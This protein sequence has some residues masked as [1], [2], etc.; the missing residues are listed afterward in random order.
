MDSGRIGSGPVDAGPS[1]GGVDTGPVDAGPRDCSIHVSLAGLDAAGRGSAAMPFRSFGQAIADAGSTDVICVLSGTY[2]EDVVIDH[3][4]EIRGNFCTAF[5]SRDPSGCK[6]TLQALAPTGLFIDGADG[7]V[8]D[9]MTI[10]SGGSSA[11]GASNYGVRVAASLGVVLRDVEI[12]ALSGIVGQAGTTGARGSDGATGST[13]STGG[14]V[15]ARASGGAAGASSCGA[16][17]GDG[18]AGAWFVDLRGRAGV[19]GAGGASGGAGGTNGTEVPSFTAAAGSDGAHG[20]AGADGSGGSGGPAFGAD[21]MDA[22]YVPRA[23]DDGTAGA[24]GGGGA[25]GGGVPSGISPRI[26]AVVG[27]S[28]EGAVSR[29]AELS[30]S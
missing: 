28:R 12:F 22:T 16:A 29:V 6:T 26:R 14:S 21:Q 10:R 11:L 18:G 3:S 4:V 5:G 24:A 19:D 7:S 17:G 23:G 30:S 13:G 25:G 8:V 27:D 1:D 2:V 20:A 9:G 15:S